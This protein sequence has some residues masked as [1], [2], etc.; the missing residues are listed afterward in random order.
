MKNFKTFIALTIMV[1]FVMSSCSKEI[2]NGSDIIVEE[3]ITKGALPS[4]LE[5]PI[6]ENNI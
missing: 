1:M 3:E 2:E 6:I 4:N 5:M